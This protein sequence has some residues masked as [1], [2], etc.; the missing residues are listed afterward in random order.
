[1]KPNEHTDPMKRIISSGM[2]TV[3]SRNFND[4]VIS[5]YLKECEAGVLKPDINYSFLLI[6]AVIMSL[7]A[8]LILDLKSTA[9]IFVPVI[10]DSKTTIEMLYIGLFAVTTFTIFT[11]ISDIV[12]DMNKEMIF[13]QY[14]EK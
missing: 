11:L 2:H 9:S 4:R 5:Q 13:S 3:P 7:L 6:S 10:T 14:A 12:E 1:M 8:G